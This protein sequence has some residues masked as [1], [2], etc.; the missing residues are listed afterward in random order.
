MLWAPI[1]QDGEN[2]HVISHMLQSHGE[3]GDQYWLVVQ[4]MHN[5]RIERLLKEMHQKC[6]MY[7]S[8]LSGV[9][10]P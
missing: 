5:K 9:L 1:Y 8:L 10:L 4:Y 3:E 2:I 6:Y 7:V